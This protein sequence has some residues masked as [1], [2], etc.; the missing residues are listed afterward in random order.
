MV[1]WRR[2]FDV[3][4]PLQFEGEGSAGL[5]ICTPPSV[6]AFRHENAMRL[7]ASFIVALLV[8]VGAI[9]FWFWMSFPT[10]SYRYRRS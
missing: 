1:G 5:Y 2:S 10:V 9:V 4:T 7:L 6:R 3:A 8:L